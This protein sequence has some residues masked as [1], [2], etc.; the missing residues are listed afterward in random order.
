VL[1]PTLNFVRIRCNGKTW[2]GTPTRAT[3]T[4]SNGG[5]RRGDNRSKLRTSAH[6]RRSVTGRRATAAHSPRPSRGIHVRDSLG[7]ASPATTQRARR[8]DRAAR[9]RA[10]S[11]ARHE[12]A[13]L[14]LARVSALRL[15]ARVDSR[16]LLSA[17]SHASGGGG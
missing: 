11:R 5:P 1:R 2:L 6:A 7:R 14:A 17:L 9:E 13:S 16:R 8:F 15:D 3:S 12:T 4:R 10:A